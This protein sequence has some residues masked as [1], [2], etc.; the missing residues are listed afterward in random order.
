MK[1]AVSIP[2]YDGKLPVQTAAHLFEELA[3]ARQMGDVV[4]IRFNP[5]CSN[6]VMGRN[7]L[8]KMFLDSDED[9]LF[10][11]DSDVTWTPGAILRLCHMPVDF[12]GGAYRLKLDH[13]EEYPVRWLD[14]PDVTGITLSDKS[15]LLDVGGIP[16][17]FLSLSRDV[18]TKLEAAHPGRRVNHFEDDFHAYFQMPFHHGLLWGEDSYFCKEWV[19]AGGKIYLDPSLELTH[20][21]FNRP[22]CGHV[23]KWLQKNGG[24]PRGMPLPDEPNYSTRALDL[25]LG[26]QSADKQTR[27][28]ITA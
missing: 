10:F 25:K 24:I 16:G 4:T 8:A 11:L 26:T 27:G 9:R 19:E 21:D 18:F 13:K 3:L 17:G 1:I 14:Q 2:V 23:G 7:V 12:V 20:W 6:V 5:N 22:Y 28:G 15:T